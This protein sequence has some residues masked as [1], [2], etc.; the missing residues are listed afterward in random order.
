[1]EPE[2]QLSDLAVEIKRGAPTSVTEV[3]VLPSGVVMLDIHVGE[4][5][6]VVCFIPKHGFGVDEIQEGDGNRPHKQNYRWTTLRLRL[7]EARRTGTC[8][9]SV[10]RA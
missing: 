6:F 2:H 1:M 9:C 8:K 4:R 7:R 10:D 3:N 5:L